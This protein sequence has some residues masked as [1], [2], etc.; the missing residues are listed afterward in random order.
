ME[1]LIV[2]DGVD[3]YN[4][5]GVHV[6]LIMRVRLIVYCFHIYVIEVCLLLYMET[7]YYR[8]HSQLEFLRVEFGLLA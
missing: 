8:S 2:F 6:G 5:S 1:H 7:P 3:Y 4:I